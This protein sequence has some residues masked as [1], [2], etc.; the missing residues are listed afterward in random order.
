MP[1]VHYCGFCHGQV[2]TID[3]MKRHYAQKA[4]CYEK[5][6]AKITKSIMAVFNDEIPSAPQLMCSPEDLQSDDGP[7]PGKI[8]VPIAGDDFIPR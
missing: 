4:G 6:Q 7:Q 5:F 2:P 3:G 8:D 1:S